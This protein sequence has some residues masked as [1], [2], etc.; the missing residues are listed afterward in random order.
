MAR[1]GSEMTKIPAELYAHHQ[2]LDSGQDLTARCAR[3]DPVVVDRT[4]LEE[5]LSKGKKH[6]H[7]RDG[8]VIFG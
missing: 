4:L 5:A 3:H 1:H 6:L 8:R 2:W 7:C